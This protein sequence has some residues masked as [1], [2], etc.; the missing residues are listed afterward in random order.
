MN[1]SK[2]ASELSKRELEKEV[3]KIRPLSAVVEKVSYVTES[4]VEL[5]IGLSEKDMM[6]LRRAQDLLSQSRGN[7]ASVE[8]V[9]IE[10]TKLY[11][12]CKDPVMKAK[13][14]L[15]KKGLSSEPV[16]GQVQEQNQGQA[17][18]QHQKSIY[19][20]KRTPI[21]A[22]ILHQVNLR[23]QRQC[24]YLNSQ[25]EKCGQ[26]RWIEI[27]HKTPVASGGKN[28]LDNLITLCSGHHQWI[29]AHD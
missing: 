18:N 24:G 14:V 5:K 15:V 23:D 2:K 3:V 27:H 8:E 28:T 11:L 26:K 19:R 10:M 22:A 21:P 29:H 9:L 6:D 4:R 1:G 16:P 12:K 25:G 13:R 17:R 7:S 20:N